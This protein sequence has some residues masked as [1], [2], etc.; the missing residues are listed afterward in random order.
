MIADNYTGPY[1]EDGY[2]TELLN[3]HRSWFEG[4]YYD[5]FSEVYADL[6]R[7]IFC[8]L[9][10]GFYILKAHEVS[11]VFDERLKFI[12]K[13]PHNIIESHFEIE[14]FCNG[15]AIVEKT[16]KSQK[17]SW[18]GND[19]YAFVNTEGVLL[20]AFQ[21][22]DLGEN[23]IADTKLIAAQKDGK[24]GIV[25][26]Y[27]KVYVPFEYDHSKLDKDWHYNSTYE[28]LTKNNLKSVVDWE[29]KQL[30]KPMYKDVYIKSDL[31]W[32]N[33]KYDYDLLRRKDMILLEG[34]N[35]DFYSY[36]YCSGINKITKEEYEA[37]LHS[38]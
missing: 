18:A 17:D 34:V 25:D 38:R 27:G 6:S 31:G 19:K 22:E 3:Y 15:V 23:F 16:F 14:A 29:G 2:A 36:N 28:I 32:Y 35:D 4:K 10:N 33:A 13:L 24:Y 20:C 37:L 9:Y 1:D 7:S 5:F 12:F 8:F 30:F 11:Y 26:V 21:Y